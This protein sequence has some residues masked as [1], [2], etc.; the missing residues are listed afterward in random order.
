MQSLFHFVEAAQD[1]TRQ[2]VLK[3]HEKRRLKIERELAERQA[4]RRLA[5]L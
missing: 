2:A 1:F 5:G 3:A 4:Q